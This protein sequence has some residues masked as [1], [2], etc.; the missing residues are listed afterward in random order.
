MIPN[1]SGPVALRLGTQRRQGRLP[2]LPSKAE[3]AASIHPMH[4][5]G[6]NHAF[7]FMG[8]ACALVEAR[9]IAATDLNESTGLSESAN[10]LLRTQEQRTPCRI[11]GSPI[12]VT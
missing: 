12:G 10:G 8:F 9:V 6:N 2:W 11:E 1:K 3:G 4:S 7:A 5:T